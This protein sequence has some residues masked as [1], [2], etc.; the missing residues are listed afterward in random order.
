MT[1]NK[2][3]RSF[4]RRSSSFF[5]SFKNTEP[6]TEDQ[7]YFDRGA[8]AAAQNRWVFEVAWEVA[9]KGRSAC[10]FPAVFFFFVCVS[11]NHCAA[12]HVVTPFRILTALLNDCHLGYLDLS[13]LVVFIMQHHRI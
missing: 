11:S 6:E 3:S 12:G 2:P 10:Q 5:R 13:I 8:T 1:E 4:R 7:F 9:N